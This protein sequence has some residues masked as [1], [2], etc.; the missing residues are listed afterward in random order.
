MHFAS[1]GLEG[2]HLKLEMNMFSSRNTHA[3]TR[4]A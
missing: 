2:E 4:E 3:A 1:S